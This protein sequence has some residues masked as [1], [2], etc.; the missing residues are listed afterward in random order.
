VEALFSPQQSLL[1]I[2]GYFAFVFS[3]TWL[4]ARHSRHTKEQFLVAERKIGALPGA[5]SVAATWIWAPALF[6]AAEK[7]YTEGVAGLFWFTVPNVA[8]LIIF[9]YFAVTIRE[10]V[11]QGYTISSYMGERFSRRVNSIYMVEL[12]GLAV[13]SFAVQ[14]LAGGY[15][16]SSLTGISFFWI[17]VLMVIIALSY[18]MLSGL[19]ASIMT[20]YLQMAFILL[21]GFTL[22]PWA[23]LRSG[24]FEN[25]LTGLGGVTGTYTSIFSGDG[26]T[27]FYT[28]GIATTIGLLAG[29]FGDQSFWQRSFAIK[30]GAVKKAFIGGALIFGLVPLTMSLLG[31]VAAGVGLDIARTDMVNIETVMALLPVWAVVLFVYM[32]MCG[33]I[34]TLD[35]N[36]CAMSSLSSHDWLNRLGGGNDRA[37]LRVSRL[38]M[39]ALAILALIIAN[40]PGMKILYLFLFYGI[41]R[42]S[43]FMPTVISLLSNKVHEAGMFWGI[44]MALIIGLPVFAYGN[45]FG[46]TAWAIAGSLLTIGL[47]GILVFAI[48]YRKGR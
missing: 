7:A 8:C 3:V 13:C 41:L 15:L 34:S 44:T 46:H 30:Q 6:V 21:I 17:T 27:V 23:V 18:S 14:L 20:D 33:L 1:L 2:A 38:S 4:T 19:R 40:I 35:S 5:F 45:F 36:L 48:S 25:V 47:S 16:I 10:K 42:A 12:V 26:A 29:P 9:A 32:L 24:G 28:F 37:V 31:F 11:P 39:V 43:V 22:V